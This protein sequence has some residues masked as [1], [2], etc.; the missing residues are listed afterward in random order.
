MAETTIEQLRAALKDCA[1][2]LESYVT[3]EYAGTLHYPSQ[4]RRFD[5]DMKP[6]REAR[7]LLEQ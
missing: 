4:K 5:R 1:D 6:V 7:A 2:D 3:N